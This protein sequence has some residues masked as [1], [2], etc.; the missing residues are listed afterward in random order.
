MELAEIALIKDKELIAFLFIW[1]PHL[2]FLLDKDK[3]EV[4]TLGFDD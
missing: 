4:L 3:N 1:K 2:D